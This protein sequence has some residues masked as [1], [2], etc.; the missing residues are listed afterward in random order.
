MAAP[1]VAGAVALSRARNPSL[2]PMQ[3]AA[4]LTRTAQRLGDQQQF[5]AGMVNAAA[6]AQ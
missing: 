1:H 3:V 5:G 2:N 6:M 4:T